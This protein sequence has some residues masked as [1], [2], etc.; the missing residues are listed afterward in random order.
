LE[1]IPGRLLVIGG[2]SIGL[3]VACVYAALGSKVTVVELTSQLMP[4]ADPDLVKPLQTRISKR[5]ENIFL[6]CRVSRV[7]IA[8]DALVARF[9]GGK[10]PASDQFD[11]ILVAVG[12]VPNG[13]K[14]GA[15][16]AGVQVTERGYIGVDAQMRTNVP[17]I[18]A[19]GD[20]VGQPMLA[21]K[22]SHEGKVAAEACAGQKSYFDAR[23]IPSVAY[24]DPEVAWVG[25][26]ESA[27]RKTGVDY[28]ASRFPWSA[29]GRAIGTDRTEG[30]TKLLFDPASKR[31]IGAG[32]TG[33]HAGDLIAE[34][35]LAIEMGCEAAD[36]SLSIHPHPTLSESIAMAAE[37]F[38]GTITDLYLPK[39][40]K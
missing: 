20:V 36:I 11:R 15:E 5:Y 4:G 9:E 22:A 38:E 39:K 18:F 28:T 17:H 30:F 23:V 29:S 35:T 19:I 13:K 8:D 37:V 27:A 31:I 3:E 16:N 10:A 7:D 33:P 25:M 24:T 26:T 1:E 12:R 2:G 21:H 32:I 34:C 40:G 6:E 14:V